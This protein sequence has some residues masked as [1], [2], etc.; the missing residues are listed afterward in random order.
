MRKVYDCGVTTTMKVIGKKWTVLILHALCTETKRFGQL[1]KEL[2]GIS[3]RTLSLR[4]D[5]LEKAKILHKK[6]YAEVPPHVEY[7]LTEKGRSLKKIFTLM[8][9]WGKQ[10]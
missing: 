8:D 1:Q 7:F 5:E 6:I 10:Q 3:P 4:L 9:A 2:D